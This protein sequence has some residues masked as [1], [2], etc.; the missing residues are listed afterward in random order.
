[1]AAVTESMSRSPFTD[2]F[3]PNGRKA[4]PILPSSSNNSPM[5]GGNDPMDITPSSTATTSMGPP[6]LSS[7]VTERGPPTNGEYEATTNGTATAVGAAAATQQPKVVQTAFIHKLYKYVYMVVW[8]RS[9]RWLM[10][11][12]ACWKIQGSSI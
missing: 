3:A 11:V 8:G 6:A 12:T 2:P 9:V 5:H 4:L 10:A 7:P 1:M